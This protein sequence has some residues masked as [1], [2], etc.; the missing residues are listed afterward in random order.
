ML[1]NVPFCLYKTESCKN[2]CEQLFNIVNK[3]K[4][5]KQINTHRNSHKKL[6]E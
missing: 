3:I 6:I 5:T 2:Y 4:V 1:N